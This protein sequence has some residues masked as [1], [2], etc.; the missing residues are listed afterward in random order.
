MLEILETKFMHI[1]LASAALL[2]VT[3]C[4][5]VG[6]KT[7]ARTSV[8]PDDPVSIAVTLYQ[9]TES[10]IDTYKLN[11]QMGL[12]ADSTGTKTQGTTYT[13]KVPSLANDTT[14]QIR[15]VGAKSTTSNVQF[16]SG[17]DGLY[18]K[19]DEVLI[20]RD[21]NGGLKGDAYVQALF[22]Q[23][24]TTQPGTT[25]Y[26]VTA[27]ITSKTPLVDICT[28]TLEC[29]PQIKN[30]H[31][32]LTKGS[33][34]SDGTCKYVNVTNPATPSVLCSKINLQCGE[35]FYAAVYNPAVTVDA[36]ANKETT[37]PTIEVL[38][39]VPTA[40]GDVTIDVQIK[41]LPTGP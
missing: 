37:L 1:S 4:Y 18:Y 34:A 8:A 12:C 20:K 17:K 5:L 31:A 16:F 40:T 36:K 9:V 23:P 30:D 25:T 6:C 15:L 2:F 13:F 11:V 39:G 19:D 21:A 14:C 3:S 26:L 28:C 7:N 38:P 41:P 22:T 32:P 33:T 27:P 35:A 29:S 10:D 24:V